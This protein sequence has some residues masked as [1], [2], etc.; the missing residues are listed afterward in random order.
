MDLEERANI[1]ALTERGRSLLDRIDTSLKHAGSEM[2]S[3]LR[4]VVNALRQIF[5]PQP[6]SGHNGSKSNGNG[7][8]L[9]RNPSHS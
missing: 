9:T 7:V 5:P 2:V 8:A 4:E 3:E 1:V 6:L